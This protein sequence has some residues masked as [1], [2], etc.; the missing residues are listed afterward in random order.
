M[1]EI[2]VAA[3]LPALDQALEAVPNRPAVFFLWPKA[4]DPYL[5]KTTVLR[6][7]LLRL[8]RER[9]TPSRLLNLRHTAIAS[10]TGLPARNS[11]PPS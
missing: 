5:G 8:L 9:E 11:N 7:R 4:G 3:A 6:R 10:N 2:P 1:P